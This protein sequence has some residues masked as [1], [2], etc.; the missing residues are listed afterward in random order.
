MTKE[1]ILRSKEGGSIPIAKI[2]TYI[3]G[4]DTILNGGIAEGRSTLVTGGP[5][6]GKSILGLEF[7]Y[8]G[9]NL[10]HAGLYVTFEE[11]EQ[12]VHENALTLGWDLKKIEQQG[13]FSV[14][15]A[16]IKQEI[17]VSGAFHFKGLYA[18][19]FAKAKEIGAKRI[20]IDA[21]DVL[22]RL[23]NNEER[24]RKELYKLHDWLIENDMTAIIT[25]K[26]SPETSVIKN[27]DFLE[28]M[29]DCVI[30]LSQ[31]THNQ[32]MTRYIRVIKYRGSRIANNEFPYAISEKGIDIIPITSIAGLQQ[33]PLG[34]HINSGHPELDRFL[35]GGYR[36]NSTILISGTSGTG[37]TSLAS[38]FVQA[39]CSQ[40][41]NVLY[42]NFEESQINMINCM[43]NAGI[44]LRP[45][46]ESDRLR[47]LSTIPESMGAEEH[48]IVAFEAI[49]DL[50]PNH[51][52]IDAISACLRM[53]S[54][55]AANAY[56][57]RIV[58]KC[59]ELGITCF[60]INQI[61]GFH[62]IQE[63][64]GI[65]I[66]SL[67]DTMILLRF[68]DTKKELIRKLLIL[69]SRGCHHSSNYHDF[70]ITDQ[71]FSFPYTNHS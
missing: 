31:S 68:V 26:A 54:V 70:N 57:I 11:N 7:L 22:L 14:L 30:K 13:H 17:I 39:S 4:L 52:V 33:K 16:R 8:R 2:K 18:T 55:Q 3:N 12:A 64:S 59:K 66:S 20:V 51:L 69:K 42:I 15:E 28:F 60:L 65:G 45:T 40:N 9:A 35:G 37:K 6:C 71:G 67:V 38:I 47:F 62:E 10:G 53:G 48:L 43:L 23:L 63:I 46:V 41:E 29:A 27:Y 32:V 56:I 44:D 58:Q 34:E 21:I 50:Q 24:E 36:Q 49:E 5:G 1:N 19:I 25:V 61:T